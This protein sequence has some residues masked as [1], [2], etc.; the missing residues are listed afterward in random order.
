MWDLRIN[1]NKE[2]HWA[3]TTGTDL[4]KKVQGSLGVV[5][6]QVVKHQTQAGQVERNCFQLGVSALC[7]LCDGLGDQGQDWPP[8]ALWQV[9]EKEQEELQV[10]HVKVVVSVNRTLDGVLLQCPQKSA[11]TRREG[12]NQARL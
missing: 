5:A 3:A 7:H 6:E 9:V 12:K 8:A 11:G 4:F 1:H 10:L 2:K